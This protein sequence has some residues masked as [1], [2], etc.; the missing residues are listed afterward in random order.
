MIG[1]EICLK[2]SQAGQGEGWNY[3]SLYNVYA[4]RLS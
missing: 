4:T 2:K 3:I 1:Y